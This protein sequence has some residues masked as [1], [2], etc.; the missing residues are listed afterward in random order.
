MNLVEQIYRLERIDRLIRRKGTGPPDA[1]S[2]KLGIS[3][4]QLFRLLDELKSYGLPIKYSRERQTYYYIREVDFNIT[5]EI[6]DK[7]CRKVL[8]GKRKNYTGSG[9][10]WYRQIVLENPNVY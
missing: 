5:F 10:H 7:D 8:G 1:F 4:R 2:R 9:E 3:P 6:R